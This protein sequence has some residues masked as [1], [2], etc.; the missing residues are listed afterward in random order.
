MPQSA[1]HV[2]PLTPAHP[3]PSRPPNPPQR[4]LVGGYLVNPMSIPAW[5]RWIRNLSPMSFAFEVRCPAGRPSARPRAGP[6]A[7]RP[8]GWAQAPGGARAVGRCAARGTRAGLCWARLRAAGPKRALGAPQTRPLNRRRQALSPLVPRPRRPHTNRAPSRAPLAH[9]PP[10]SS[11]VLAAN[12]MADQMYSLKV[13]GFAQLEG[14]K[15]DVFLRTLGLV[16]SRALESAVALAC[17]YVGSVALAFAATS[18]T[19]WAHGGGS[20]RRLLTRPFRR[21]AEAEGQH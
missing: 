3:T 6:A 21:A 1:P 17:F 8:A 12:E 2:G 20:F 5:L 10:H 15:G 9:P 18:Y 14:I 7:R 13:A 11:Q 19:L 4:V 16:P